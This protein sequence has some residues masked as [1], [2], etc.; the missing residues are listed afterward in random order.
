MKKLAI[1]PLIGLITN[2]AYLGIAINHKS[3]PDVVC[4]TM[5]STIFAIGVAVI[6][7]IE[8]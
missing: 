5:M 6:L 4:A 1:I 7:T 2:L 3:T 8:D